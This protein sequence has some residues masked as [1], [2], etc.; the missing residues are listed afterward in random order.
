MWPSS[1]HFITL[2]EP[3]QSTHPRRVWQRLTII[4]QSSCK[5][6]S[7]HPRRVWPLGR[8]PRQDRCCFNPHTHEGCDCTWHLVGALLLR[9]QSTHP[10][11][12]WRLRVKKTDGTWKFQ[13][14]HPRRVWRVY[15]HLIAVCEWFQSTHPRRV[16]LGGRLSTIPQLV[17]Q[18]TH[19]RRV[20]HQADLPRYYAVG[21]NPHTHEGCDLVLIVSSC[22]ISCFNPHTHEGCDRRLMPTII[23]LRKFQSTHP[24]RVWLYGYYIFVW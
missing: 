22:S 21:F 10:R 6:Q 9:F 23:R 2:D 7:T 18:S 17:F 20:W 15:V 24:R 14:T 1:A 12:V 19:P 13:S 3:F 16:W 11:R 5:F 8:Y 4:K